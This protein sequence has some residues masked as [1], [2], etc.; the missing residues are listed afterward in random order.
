MHAK[1]RGAF[2]HF[3]IQG[4]INPV[5][6]HTMVRGVSGSSAASIGDRLSTAA[7]SRK[8]NI[9]NIAIYAPAIY[10]VYFN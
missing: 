7:S 3:N 9:A 2:T 8:A 6:L 10:T 4:S 5:K 1:R